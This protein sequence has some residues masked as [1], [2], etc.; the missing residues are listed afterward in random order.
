MLLFFSLTPIFSI[1]PENAFVRTYGAFFI[2]GT[3]VFGIE[4]R[5]MP[6]ALVRSYEDLRTNGLRVLRLY[7]IRFHGAAGSA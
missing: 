5:G 6:K 7:S 1:E 4:R 2:C 3:T